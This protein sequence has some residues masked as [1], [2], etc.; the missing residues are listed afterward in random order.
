VSLADTSIAVWDTASWR[1]AIDAAVAKAVPADLARLWD[2]LAADAPT[3]L[4]AA[5]LLAAAGDKGIALLKGKLPARSAPAADRMD[6][7]IAD[8]DSPRF[9]AREKAEADLRDLGPQAEP[10]LH[11]AL[12][13]N[14]SAEAAKRLEAVL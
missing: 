1:T 8:L 4:R 13:A 12:K 11:R 3:G 5:R 9:G 6:R 2:D 10:F 7:L 14:P